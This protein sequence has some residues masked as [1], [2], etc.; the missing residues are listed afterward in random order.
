MAVCHW[1]KMNEGQK[2]KK[3]RGTVNNHCTFYYISGQLL[4]GCH[5]GL[6]VEKVKQLQKR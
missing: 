5:I 1:E 4:M 2:A 6:E 3:H